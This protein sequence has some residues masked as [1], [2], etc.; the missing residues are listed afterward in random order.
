MANGIHFRFRLGV[1]YLVCTGYVGL[2]TV[3]KAK[4]FLDFV[5]I[6]L[7]FI[8]LMFYSFPILEWPHSTLTGFCINLP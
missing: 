3:W 4:I 2:I 5:G 6:T 8:V 7:L 1:L